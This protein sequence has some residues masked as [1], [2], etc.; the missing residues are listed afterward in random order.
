LTSVNTYFG[1]SGS[2]TGATIGGGGALSTAMT[3]F[4]GATG[5]GISFFGPEPEHPAS[6]KASAAR[7]NNWD[8]IFFI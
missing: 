6:K 1:G 3:G 5:R 2:G 4:G 7:I 8:V